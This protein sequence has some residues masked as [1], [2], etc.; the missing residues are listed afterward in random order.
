MF[1]TATGMKF[2]QFYDWKEECRFNII[3]VPCSKLIDKIYSNNCT[4]I[5]ENKKAIVC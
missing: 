3:H 2:I 1:F 5:K 4:T